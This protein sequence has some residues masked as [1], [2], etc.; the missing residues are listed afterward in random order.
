MKSISSR[1]CNDLAGASDFCGCFGA[2]VRATV[3]ANLQEVY[4]STFVGYWMALT[5]YL[6][7]FLQWAY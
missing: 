3:S 1:N 6:F 7:Q 2:F 5:K 4:V